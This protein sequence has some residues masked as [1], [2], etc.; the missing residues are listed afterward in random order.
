MFIFAL[1]ALAGWPKRAIIARGSQWVF[2]GYCSALSLA[3]V[4]VDTAENGP[5]KVRQVT[6]KVCRN[7]GFFSRREAPPIFSLPEFCDSAVVFSFSY[8]LSTS[9]HQGVRGGEDN[10]PGQPSRPGGDWI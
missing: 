10:H 5:S 7:L 9:L 1:F 8:I 6:N 2:E 3:I 4:A